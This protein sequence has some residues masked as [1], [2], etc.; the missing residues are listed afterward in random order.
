MQAYFI[1]VE[2]VTLTRI[3]FYRGYAVSGLIS[4]PN[5]GALWT[6]GPVITLNKCY[7]HWNRADDGKGGAIYVGGGR[8]ILHGVSFSGSTTANRAKNGDEIY[9]ENYSAGAVV[10]ISEGCP[11]GYEGPATQG[12]AIDVMG[13]FIGTEA[14]HTCTAICPAGRYSENGNTGDCTWCPD[15]KYLTDDSADPMKHDSQGDCVSCT[16]GRY[17]ASKTVQFCEFCPAGTY[18][19]TSAAGVCSGC[20]FGKYNDHEPDGQFGHEY[21]HDSVD[22][23]T[24]CEPGKFGPG[25]GLITCINCG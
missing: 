15:G 23:C 4:I 1:A 12:G 8:V 24:N 14:S 6:S 2:E 3:K 10:I 13:N 11:A 22:D 17:A 18:T 25:E 9:P 5:G 20:P 7:F 16:R 19:K 21:F